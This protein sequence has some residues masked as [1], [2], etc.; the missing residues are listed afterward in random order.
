MRGVAMSKRTVQ[1]AFVFGL[2]CAL[3]VPGRAQAPTSPSDCETPHFVPTLS[4]SMTSEVS[5]TDRHVLELDIQSSGGYDTVR[6]VDLVPELGTVQKLTIPDERVPA[7]HPLVFL[8]PR[9]RLRRNTDFRVLLT[10][11]DSAYGPSCVILQKSIIGT[12]PK[13]TIS[14]LAGP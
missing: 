13:E 6:D 9:D 12:I 4:F 11:S 3:P 8:I 10:V 14:K 2:L 7:G 5:A 1:K